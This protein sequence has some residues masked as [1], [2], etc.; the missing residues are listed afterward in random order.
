MNEEQKSQ[1]KPGDRCDCFPACTLRAAPPA[2]V[3][4]ADGW[5]LVPVEPTPEIM[6]AASIAAWPVASESD[7]ALA[8]SAARIILM[9][10]D[11]TPGATLD[12]VAA[13]IATMAPAYRAMLAAAPRYAPINEAGKGD[14]VAC[15]RCGG[16]KF[17]DDGEIA[18]SGGV[19]FENGPVKCVKD[20]PDCTAPQPSASPAGQVED[21]VRKLLTAA[22][23]ALRSYQYGNA[24]PD[25]AESIA[26]RIDAAIAKGARA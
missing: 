24:V 15:E 26:D 5:Q 21:V 7:L 22:S 10:M 23:H 6:A 25:L 14:V 8:R 12:S 20:C 13:A 17:V 9:K 3:S 18:G 11:A 4:E 2:P 1:C 19:Q 16:S